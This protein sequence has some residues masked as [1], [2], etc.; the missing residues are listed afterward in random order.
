[1]KGHI[2]AD[3]TCSSHMFITTMKKIIYFKV[4]TNINYRI[5][6]LT[7]WATVILIYSFLISTMYPTFWLQKDKLHIPNICQLLWLW[8]DRSWL[9][10]LVRHTLDTLP[11]ELQHSNDYARQKYDYRR[12]SIIHP[13]FDPKYYRWTD[14][15]L[16]KCPM[17][18]CVFY[19]FEKFCFLLYVYVC[20]TNN[21][22]LF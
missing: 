1:M 11:I 10:I 3:H 19:I 7:N 14:R 8:K 6:H 16:V 2:L 18:T 22:F 20:V 13:T 21:R 5:G 15:Q 9:T 12:T 4:V 17:H